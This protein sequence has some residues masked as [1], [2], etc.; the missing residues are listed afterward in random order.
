[1]QPQSVYFRGDAT[2][3]SGSFELLIGCLP[4]A[5]GND[6]DRAVSSGVHEGMREGINDENYSNQA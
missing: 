3:K 5:Q 4:C 6:P 1:M 2:T